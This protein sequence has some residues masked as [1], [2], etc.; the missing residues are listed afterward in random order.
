MNKEDL[1]LKLIA[2]LLGSDTD[3]QESPVKQES[4]LAGQG[5][6][7]RCRDAGV[8]YGK[9]VGYQGRTVELK[10]SRRMWHWHSASENT[11]SGV[12]RCGINQEK[13][14]IQGSLTSIILQDACEII[15]ISGDAEQSILSA[16]IYNE[17][18]YRFR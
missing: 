15:P 5:V 7:V 18:Q 14:K 10:D 2:M 4:S 8:H 16:E 1:A 17:Q 9:L 11:L 6:I 12:A 13:S 3:K